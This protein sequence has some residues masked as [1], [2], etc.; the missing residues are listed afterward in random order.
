MANEK[1]TKKAGLGLTIVALLANIAATAVTFTGCD[2][3]IKEDPIQKEEYDKN[4]FHITTGLHRETGKPWN[5]EGYDKN[6]DYYYG[7]EF[8]GEGE[9]DY[10]GYDRDGYNINGFDRDGYDKDGYDV[11]GWNEKGWNSDLNIID[12]R[13]TGKPHDEDGMERDGKTKW[14]EILEG[15]KYDYTG[16]TDGTQPGV[17]AGWHWDK[18]NIINNK[19]TGKP[20]DENGMERDGVTKWYDIINDIKY[21]YTGFTDGTQPGI[22]AGWHKDGYYLTPGRETDDNGKDIHGN[23]V[24]PTIEPVPSPELFGSHLINTQSGV[25][26]AVRYGKEDLDEQAGLISDQFTEHGTTNTSLRDSVIHSCT[27]PTGNSGIGDSIISNGMW[28]ISNYIVN[29]KGQLPSDQQERFSLLM[30][31]YRTQAYVDYRGYHESD[32]L[33]NPS[34][35]ELITLYN[36]LDGINP[37]QINTY[38]NNTVIPYLSETLD[39][40]PGLVRTLLNQITSFE[41]FYAIV[42][43]ARA[44]DFVPVPSL[45]DIPSY[46]P[47]TPIRNLDYIQEFITAAESQQ[48]QGMGK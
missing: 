41:Q 46:N 36:Q 20:H 42:D 27:N 38:F 10:Q 18:D 47:Q 37:G 19:L 21:D 44:Q 32:P 29:I 23:T 22:I 24:W 3:N 1:K 28:S 2:H 7:K 11:E 12:N 13:L 9:Y 26:S 4:G 14:Y 43:D 5:P 25:T 45:S 30:N 48:N 17:A 15:I 8:Y 31:T 16:Y 35:A 34:Q 40:N 6:G 33:K 39:I